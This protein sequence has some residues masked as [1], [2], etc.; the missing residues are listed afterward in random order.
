M[1][2]VRF[3]IVSM[4]IEKQSLHTG[5]SESAR[6][7]ALV[8]SAVARARRRRRNARQT[9]ARRRGF[10]LARMY[11]VV[12]SRSQQMAN[13]SAQAAARALAASLCVQFSIPFCPF[14]SVLLILPV[15]L[16]G[17]RRWRRVLDRVL[18][19]DQTFALCVVF[20]EKPTQILQSEGA[21]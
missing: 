5:G 9:P 11:V 10:A 15:R 6:P 13:R 16:S 17:W 1:H 4:M 12:H 8:E 2:L 18:I 21:I 14:C 19:F 20:H 3:H 7:Y